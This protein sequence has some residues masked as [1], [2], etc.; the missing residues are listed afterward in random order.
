MSTMEREYT[1]ICINRF[2][3]FTSRK[4]VENTGCC[5]KNDVLQ[6]STVNTVYQYIFNVNNWYQFISFI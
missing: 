2:F 5:L 1:R 3:L 6:K 4:C